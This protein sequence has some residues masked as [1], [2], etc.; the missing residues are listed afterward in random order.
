MRCVAKLASGLSFVSDAG[1]IRSSCETAIAS[2]AAG[3]SLQSGGGAVRISQSGSPCSTAC[4]NS[5]FTVLVPMPRGGVLM[6]RKSEGSSV[7][8]IEHAQVGQNVFHFAAIVKRLPAN[9]HVRHF[10][11]AQFHFERPR[12]F[13]GAAQNGNVARLDAGVCQPQFDIGDN[14]L[15]LFGFILA[16]QNDRPQAACARGPQD[17]S[18]RLRLKAISRLAKSKIA[19]QV[20]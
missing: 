10:L 19:S 5:A 9:Q 12:L 20:R 15:G 18:C 14:L 8:I 17:F 11:A 6:I 1:A 16:L 4:P 7:R 13:V 3:E 2:D